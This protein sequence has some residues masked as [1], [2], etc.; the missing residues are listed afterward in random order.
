MKASEY[1]KD[2]SKIYIKIFKKLV[3][4]VGKNLDQIELLQGERNRY[5]WPLDEHE[6]IDGEKS[7]SYEW[8]EKEEQRYKKWLVNYIY[9]HR[10]K[11]GLS[12][13]NKEMIRDKTVGY[14]LLMY[15]WRYKK[16]E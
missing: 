7:Y 15:G 1:F 6:L 16:D 14:F 3:S 5:N 8:T 9:R 12:Y 13:A 11:L 2:E 4:C 10:K